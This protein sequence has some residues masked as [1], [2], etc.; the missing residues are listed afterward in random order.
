M[1]RDMAARGDLGRITM[2]DTEF[3]NSAYAGGA[4]EAHA[5]MA[6]D[7]QPFLELIPGI[8]NG[9]HTIDVVEAALRSHAAGQRPVT[10]AEQ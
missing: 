10:L 3:A 5:L 9:V 2:I 8:D 7:S 6:D 4:P 1:A